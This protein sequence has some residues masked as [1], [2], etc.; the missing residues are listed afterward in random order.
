MDTNLNTLSSALLQSIDAMAQSAADSTDRT[1]TIEAKIVEVIDAGIGTY[2]VEYLGNTFEATAAH[3]EIVYDVDEMVYVIVPCGDFDKNKV[4][5]SPVSPVTA[6]YAST[7]G[8]AS[9]ITLGDN[10]FASVA[11][12]ELYNWFC[13]AI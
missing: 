1:L 6:T 8:G 7:Q 5:L 4:I 9:F 2:K 10:L 12:V 13:T 11:D 3:T